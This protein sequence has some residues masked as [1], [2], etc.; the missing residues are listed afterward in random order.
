MVSSIRNTT[1]NRQKMIN[2]QEAYNLWDLLNSK[3]FAIEQIQIA[4][5]FA[6]D[7]DFAAYYW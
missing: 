3:Y 6:H 7:P 4:E 1:E 5:N 2:I